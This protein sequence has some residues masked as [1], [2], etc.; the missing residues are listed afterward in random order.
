RVDLPNR[1]MDVLVDDAEMQRRRG[2]H[3]P[4]PARYTTGALAK[5]AKLVGSAERGA[6]LD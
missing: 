5:Y 4:Y 3:T 1:T 6:V 2:D